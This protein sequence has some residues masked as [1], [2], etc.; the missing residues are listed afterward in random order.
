MNIISDEVTAFLDSLEHPLR[1]E[2]DYLRKLILSSEYELAEGIKWN[3]PNY[4]SN[5]EDRITMRLHPQRQVQIIFHRGAKK[6]VQPEDK[7]LKGEYDFLLW[8]ENDRAIATFSRISDIEKNACKLREIV[9][10]WIEV[11]AGC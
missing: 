2:I 1:V 7:L 8:K 4:S 11:T 10:R 6:S 3:G 9:D 5:G